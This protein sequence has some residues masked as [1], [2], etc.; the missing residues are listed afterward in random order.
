MGGTKFVFAGLFI[1][2]FVNHWLVQVVLPVAFVLV[3]FLWHCLI[4]RR[5]DVS[6]EIRETINGMEEFLDETEERKIT[7]YVM[8]FVHPTLTRLVISVGV[9]EAKD[10][11]VASWSMLFER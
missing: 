1:G 4:M 5:A 8:A 9:G 7:D 2:L 10:L 6:E 3:W 11:T